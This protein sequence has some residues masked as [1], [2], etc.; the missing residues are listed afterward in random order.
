MGVMQMTKC[1]ECGF[2]NAQTDIC[3]QCNAALASGAA[4][5]T[6]YIVWCNSGGKINMESI[7]ATE[8]GANAT[9]KLLQ[10]GV[11]KFEE[12]YVEDIEVQP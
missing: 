8:V 3:S 12:Y 9:A 2:E 4:L 5:A 1:P 7:H 6:V 10:A 11:G